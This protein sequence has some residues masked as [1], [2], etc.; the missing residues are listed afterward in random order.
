MLEIQALKGQEKITML[1]AYDYPTAMV[2]DQA[3]I[4][5]ILVGDSL[6]NVILGQP[7]TLGVT[8]EHMIHHTKAV[9]QGVKKSFVVA[10]MPF[11]TYQASTEQAVQNATDLIAKGGAHAVKLEGG[12]PI[13]STVERLVSI[14]IPVMG[15]VGL[16]P[17][18]VHQL[19][20]Y[21]TQGK[22]EKKAKQIFEDACALEKAGAFA[23]VLEC[24]PEELAQ[25]IT[26]TLHI[27]T[28]GIGSGAKTDG[29]V[30][31]FHDLVGFTPS[32]IPSFVHPVA[33]IFEDLT[34]H[35][36]TFIARTKEMS[37]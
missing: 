20:G 29:Q 4:D 36:K 28:I 15:H 16:T 22:S 37:S 13:L 21:K 12:K 25:K 6:G 14:G 33:H 7:H 24:I 10:D 9:S 27:P 2:L 3:G 17:Q 35:V 8:L 5:I 23:I 32:H 26:D 34:N 31:V 19:G 1:T 30:L 18:S 11:G